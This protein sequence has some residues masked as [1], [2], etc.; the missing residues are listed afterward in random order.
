MKL[1]SN[2]DILQNIG[3]CYRSTKINK[4]C[5]V[6]NNTYIRPFI[7]YTH[8]HLQTFQPSYNKLLLN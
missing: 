4:K 1:S 6:L 3:K 5:Y 2:V 8:E 7:F